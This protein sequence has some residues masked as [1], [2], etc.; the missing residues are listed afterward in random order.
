VRSNPR[1]LGL[2]SY[3]LICFVSCAHASTCTYFGD[4]IPAAT[5][6]VGT[7]NLY[8]NLSIDLS[9]ATNRVNLLKLFYA[10]GGQQYAID[11]PPVSVTPPTQTH[12]ASNITTTTTFI[13]VAKRDTSGT[14]CTLTVP[15]NIPADTQAV[16]DDQEC[17]QGHAFAGWGPNYPG[18]QYPTNYCVRVLPPYD[19]A[20]YPDYKSTLVPPYGHA[21]SPGVL[22]SG[23]WSRRS[24]HLSYRQLEHHQ[25]DYERPNVLTGRRSKLQPIWCPRAG[26]LFD[27]NGWPTG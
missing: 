27:S 5:L 16:P 17:S 20:S 7:N 25:P 23:L 19:T 2:A 26:C 3:L 14:I 21:C 9:I 4:D 6:D 8:T 18:T 13:L 12:N 1:S 22:R 24:Y 10:A 15:Y 11:L